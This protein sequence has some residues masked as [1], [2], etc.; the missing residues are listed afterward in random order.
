MT[1]FPIAAKVT[2]NT[3]GFVS[4]MAAG[5]AGL[6]AFAGASKLA[7]A[8]LAIL[9]GKAIGEGIAAAREFQTELIKLNT[10]VGLQADQIDQYAESMKGLSTEVGQT[11][12]DLARA[13]FA[14][15]SG[16]ARGAEAMSI[17]EQAS[18]ASAVGL[19]DMTEI[20]RTATAALQAFGDT[21]LTAEK[22]IDVMLATVRAGN[23]EAEELAGSFGKVM[24][25]A[26]ALG[27]SFEDLGAFVATYTRLGVNARVATTS[28]NGTL[29]L[30]L[31]PTKEARQKMSE[32]GIPVEHLR[33]VLRNDGL[34]AALMEMKD[35]IGDDIDAIG[36]VIPNIRALGGILGTVG[37]QAEAYSEIQKD[38]NESLG[39]TAEGFATWSQSADATFKRFE[40][41]AQVFKVA[42]G[43]LF[44]PPLTAVLDVLSKITIVMGEVVDMVDGA[45][46]TVIKDAGTDWARLMAAL[47]GEEFD[48]GSPTFI[49]KVIADLE[50]MTAGELQ[51]RLEHATGRLATLQNTMNRGGMTDVGREE[52][53]LYAA[54]V[55]VL[56]GLIRNATEAQ[57]EAVT[58]GE[59]VRGLTLEQIEAEEKRQEAIA[60]LVDG[61]QQE[62][63]LLVHGEREMLRRLMVELEMEPA[64]IATTLARYDNIQAIRDEIEAER[65]ATE[66][67]E[68][69]REE[70]ERGRQ[71]KMRDRKEAA[72]RAREEAR[73]LAEALREA[74]IEEEMRLIM[75]M[76]VAMADSIGEAFDKIVT[77]T[78]SV[79]DAF[80]DMVTEILREIRRMAIQKAIVDPLISTIFGAAGAS[81][82][83]TSTT[84]AT[85]SAKLSAP[86]VTGSTGKLMASPVIVQQSI[87]FSPNMIDA[88]SARRFFN[89]NAGEI[90]NIVGEAAQQS[91][92]FANRLRGG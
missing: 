44:L 92:G 42:V 53:R 43:T 7:A 64:L 80:G 68:R 59:R 32:L 78:E 16:G 60:D 4:A 27:I 45:L 1:I 65:E 85:T 51:G 76:S 61:L 39:L 24:G 36:Q 75:D 49:E 23:L 19:G 20:G 90:T 13:M 57:Q 46:T 73:E 28:L 33:D 77:K 62:L 6:G 89:E 41:S 67:K 22:A 87:Q 10:L 11:P 26:S 38:I 30:L 55:H 70:A 5:T 8:A 54:Q 17:L 81:S 58:T 74:K 40:A 69:L 12:A 82:G 52:M 84:V 3:G 83:S 31:R 66:I 29:N 34:N 72:E 21:G 35:A 86:I 37:V 2:A 48:D 15:T 79:A 56:P 63:D 14:I 25:T 88:Q 50:G 47:K 71:Q 91:T 9:T 18:K